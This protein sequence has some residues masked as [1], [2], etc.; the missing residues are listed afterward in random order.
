VPRRIGRRGSDSRGSTS[1]EEPMEV[2]DPA[3]QTSPEHPDPLREQARLSK[4]RPSI[5][6]LTMLPTSSWWSSF[7]LPRTKACCQIF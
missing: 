7:Q 2:K 5:R 1:R 6:R 3:V 4:Q